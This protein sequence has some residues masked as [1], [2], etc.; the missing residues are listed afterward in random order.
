[1]KSARSIGFEECSQRNNGRKVKSIYNGAFIDF[2]T[3]GSRRVSL[4]VFTQTVIG[5]LHL[6]VEVERCYLF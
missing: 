3:Y 5:F 2:F 6:E 4:N 1:M